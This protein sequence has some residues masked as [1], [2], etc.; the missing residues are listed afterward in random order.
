[1]PRRIPKAVT[2]LFEASLDTLREAFENEAIL[3]RVEAMDDGLRRLAV[4]D[5]DRLFTVAHYYADLLH[6]APGVAD[7]YDLPRYRVSWERIA[8]SPDTPFGKSTL[9]ECRKKLGIKTIADLRA[10]ARELDPSN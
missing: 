3:I 10:K 2:E 5:D 9:H 4:S 7:Y 6:R 8:L 1:M